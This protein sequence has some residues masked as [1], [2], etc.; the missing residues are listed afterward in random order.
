MIGPPTNSAAA[1]CQPSRTA[2]ST[3]SSITRLVEANWKAMAAMKSAPLRKSERA[4]AVAAYEHDELAAPRAD[5][6]TM[7]LA[8]ESG[9]SLL[10]CSLETTA[11]MM[12]ERMKPRQSAQRISQ[13][14]IPVIWSA[15]AIWQKQWRLL[16]ALCC[17]G[18]LIFDGRL[19]KCGLLRAL[20][21]KTR[22]DVTGGATLHLP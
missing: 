13:A 5:A 17:L 11:S 22:A 12:A 20:C 1:N 15:S 7:V 19:R 6:T 10:T 2:I 4:S 8:E 16:S 9:R 3:L 21:T 18:C 14:M